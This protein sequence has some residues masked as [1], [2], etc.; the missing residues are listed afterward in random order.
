MFANNGRIAVNVLKE[1][2][3]MF[4]IVLMDINMP[5]M[6]GYTATEMIR[7]DQRFD[8]LPIVAFT[9]LAL[10][11]E[12]EKIFKVGM[13]AYLTKPINIGKLYSVFKMFLA[14][15]PLV[16]EQSKLQIST[17]R[18]IVPKKIDKEVLDTEKG[19]LYSNRNEGFYMEILHE[20]LDAYGESAE[21][22]AKLVREHRYEQI[23]MLCLDMKGLTGTIGAQEMYRLVLEIHQYILYRKEELLDTLV[24]PYEEKLSRLKQSITDYLER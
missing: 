5:V 16:A 17:Q 15:K 23:K 21:V 13:N 22:F 4:D 11:N 3:E 8:K 19:I 20:F 14:G 2:E 1:S 12:R 10:E 6:D 24:A 18:T 9:A 7:K